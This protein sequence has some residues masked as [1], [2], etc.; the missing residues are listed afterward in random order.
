MRETPLSIHLDSDTVVLRSVGEE[1]PEPAVITGSVVL[2]L[3][4]RA[5]IKD[6]QYV[7]SS[8]FIA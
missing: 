6:V 1:E 5:D 3:H 4:E 8:T 2:D 7:D